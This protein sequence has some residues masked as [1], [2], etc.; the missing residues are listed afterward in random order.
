[1]WGCKADHI[2]IHLM[3]RFIRFPR[4]WKRLEFRIS[5]HLMLRFI[6]MLSCLYEIYRNFNTSHV[7]VYLKNSALKLGTTMYF[8][9]SHVTVYPQ[10]RKWLSR[11]EKI[12][13]HLMLRFIVGNTVIVLCCTSHFNTSH[14]TVYRLPSR[15]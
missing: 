2:S 14:V 6:Y 11:K 9:T 7:T 15:K 3:L 12:S 10:S 13:I 5:I 8:N 4:Q 1:M